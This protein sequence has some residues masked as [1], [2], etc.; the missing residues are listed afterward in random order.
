MNKYNKGKIYKIVDDS[1]NNV[2]YGSTIEKYIS[3]RLAKHKTG[4]KRYLLGKRKYVSSFD[5]LKNN[6]YHIELVKEVNCNNNFQL[7]ERERYYIVNFECVNKYIPNR[8][9]K[10]YYIDNKDKNKDK[11]KD[12]YINNKEMI[13]EQHKKY[14]IKNKDKR[15]EYDKNKYQYNKTIKELYNIDISIFI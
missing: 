11:I 2:Y 6:N 7:K 4:Y 12:Y 15:K 1:N 10:E 5:I 8:T 14:N 3:N 13:N 9:S